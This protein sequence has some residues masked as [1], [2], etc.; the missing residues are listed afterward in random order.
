MKCC[1]IRLS[2]A[3]FRDAPG[4][5]VKALGWALVSSFMLSG[6]GLAAPM[7]IAGDLA[8]SDLA[9][10]ELTSDELAS[11]GDEPTPVEA[12]VQHLEGVMS[13]AS[14][15]EADPSFVAVQ[16]TTCR[17][18]MNNPE[19]NSVFL[20]QEQ[21]LVEGLGSPY[22][23]RFLQITDGARD[24]VD[25]IT[26]KPDEMD[27]WVDFCAQPDRRISVAD[28]GEQVCSVALRTAVIGGFVG[29]TPTNGCPSN[30]RGAV[31]ITNVV[32]LHSQGMDTWDRGLD[33][34]GNQ[35]W[36]AEEIPYRYRR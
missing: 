32:V 29:S 8:N 14:Q 27:R 31:R 21:A 34:A 19:P 3:S 4:A 6:P 20:Y 10:N 35:V 28:L 26:F 13:T 33:A 23:Q 1:A 24:R 5:A 25:S 15:A 7:L 9:N 36:G 17:V 18:E 12:V 2:C 30:V 22:R 11:R 16:M